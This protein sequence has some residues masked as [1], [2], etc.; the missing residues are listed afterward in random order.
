MG[1]NAN[2]NTLARLNPFT[3]LGYIARSKVIDLFYTITWGEP[4]RRT[5]RETRAQS[6][7]EAPE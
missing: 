5:A 6:R 7:E 2:Y 4:P 3:I 1:V